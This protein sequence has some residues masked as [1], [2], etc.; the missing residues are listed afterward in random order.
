[1][2]HFSII[3]FLFLINKVKM[4]GKLKDLCICSSVDPDGNRR[5]QERKAG[6]RSA[7]EGSRAAAAASAAGAVARAGRGESRRV[8]GGGS[9]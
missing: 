1:M 6:W 8:G 4:V 2:S 7:G 9:R 3:Y 5:A